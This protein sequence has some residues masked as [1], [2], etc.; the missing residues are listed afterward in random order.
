MVWYC[1]LMFKNCLVTLLMGANFCILKIPTLSRTKL[2]I[3]SGIWNLI[4][5][6]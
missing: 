4:V 6:L 2:K 5:T 1:I 3:L